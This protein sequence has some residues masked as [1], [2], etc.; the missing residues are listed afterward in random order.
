MSPVDEVYITVVDIRGLGISYFE[1]NRYP[2]QFVTI[3]ADAEEGSIFLQPNVNVTIHSSPD[4]SPDNLLQ[5]MVIHTSCSQATFLN[6]CYGSLVLVSFND[7][8][9]GNVTCIEDAQFVYTIT[10][11]DTEND[12]TL[13]TMTTITSVESDG[14]IDGV[15]D[16]TDLVA[17]EVLSPGQVDTFVFDVQINGNSNFNN[18]IFTTLS[19]EGTVGGAS[20][21]ST[22]ST[23]FV[24]GDPGGG[25]GFHANVTELLDPSFGV[26]PATP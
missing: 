11:S 20:C 9:Q 23:S 15:V 1:G 25:T 19:G 14:V 16:L 5:T 8:E 21:G 7:T 2:G 10:N 12:A 6:D 4:K 22:N 3:N 17:G 13:S 26:D 18:T 24:T